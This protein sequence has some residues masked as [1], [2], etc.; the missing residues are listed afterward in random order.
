MQSALIEWTK[1]QGYPS[2]RASLRAS[3]NKQNTSVTTEII[4]VKSHSKPLVKIEQ[5]DY[6]PKHKNPSYE[7]LTRISKDVWDKLEDGAKPPKQPVVIDEIKRV[8]REVTG[9][10]LTSKNI[11]SQIDAIAR[12]PKFK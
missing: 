12:P 9:D 7:V 11:V 2:L 6:I 3:E 1:K 5:I 8:Y 10:E 4:T